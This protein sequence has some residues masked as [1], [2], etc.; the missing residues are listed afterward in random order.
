MQWVVEEDLSR[1]LPLCGLMGC[2]MQLLGHSL[3]RLL[4]GSQ[5]QLRHSMPGME[6]RWLR[7]LLNRRLAGALLTLGTACPLW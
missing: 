2:K 3:R 4:K 5:A 1:A 7:L 6:Q